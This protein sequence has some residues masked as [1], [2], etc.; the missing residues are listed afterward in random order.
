M[1]SHPKVGANACPRCLMIHRIER[2]L[3]VAQASETAGWS[4]RSAYKKRR[5]WREVGS[6]G[7]GWESPPFANRGRFSLDEFCISD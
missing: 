2:G 3:P 4:E 7:I 5:R 6:V 1:R